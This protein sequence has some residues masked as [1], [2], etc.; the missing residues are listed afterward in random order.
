MADPHLWNTEN[1]FFHQYRTDTGRLPP[2]TDEK[3]MAD[4]LSKEVPCFL[5]FLLSKFD[6]YEI[7]QY[8]HYCTAVFVC[9]HYAAF[10]VQYPES[11]FP[12]Y[13]TAVFPYR[14]KKRSHSCLS[15][16]PEI[17]SS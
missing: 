10:L 8:N 1:S 12:P 9:I 5:L 16:V 15:D 4:L 13:V 17:C 14:F 6:F 2:C 7:L 3:Y 11:L